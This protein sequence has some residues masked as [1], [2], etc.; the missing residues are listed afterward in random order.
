M[1]C[2]DKLNYIAAVLEDRYGIIT[3]GYTARRDLEKYFKNTNF[4]VRGSGFTLPMGKTF[5]VPKDTPVGWSE[6]YQ[7]TVCNG[8]CKECYLT[9]SKEYG[10]VA[11]RLSKGGK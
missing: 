10:N 4:V 8:V 6:K 5:T 3:Y 7:A 11:M 2:I 9:R 1:T